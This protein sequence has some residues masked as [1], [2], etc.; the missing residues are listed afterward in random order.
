MMRI[1]RSCIDIEV[2]KLSLDI[3]AG[4]EGAQNYSLRLAIFTRQNLGKLKS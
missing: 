1:T 3:Q 4:G 2:L